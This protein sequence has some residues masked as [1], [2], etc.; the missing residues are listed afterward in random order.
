LELLLKH[1]PNGS[2]SRWEDRYA[3]VT[4]VTL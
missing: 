2:Y 3:R 1:T 4:V